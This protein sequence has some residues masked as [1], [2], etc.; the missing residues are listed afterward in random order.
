MFLLAGDATWVEG[1]LFTT[2][3]LSLYT[4]VT[5]WMYLKDPA[6]LAERDR[7][8]Q[9]ASASTGGRRQTASDRVS[10]LLLFLGFAAWIVLMPLDARRFGWTPALSLSLKTF[11]GALLLLSAFP[12][13]RAFYDNTFLSG[14]VRVQSDRG[15]R[16]VSTGVYAFVR[17]PMY[18]GIVLMFTGTPLLL[19]SAMG[20]GIAV[21]MVVLLAV[22]ID[23][24]ERLLADELDGYA[25]YR[26]KVRY[27]L[28]PF[29]W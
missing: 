2:W 24:E 17:H 6:L 11:G 16:V 22:R 13:F 14:V 12:L 15:Q 5:L 20:L 25:E 10:V 18:L 8:S 27:R 7:R 26:R 29:I 21:A 23:A 4:T 28:V 3:L 9:S 19:G 1:W